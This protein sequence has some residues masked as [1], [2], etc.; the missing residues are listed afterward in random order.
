ML[1][2]V[3]ARWEIGRWQSRTAHYLRFSRNEATQLLISSNVPFGQNHIW[4]RHLHEDQNK[5]CHGVGQAQKAAIK[6]QRKAMD[7]M[8][9][10]MKR[11]YSELSS[12]QAELESA[13]GSITARS[14]RSQQPPP[15]T[16]L[17]ALR[18]L[19]SP[20]L[21]T[22]EQIVTCSGVWILS[23]NIILNNRLSQVSR[24]PCHRMQSPMNSR[25]PRPISSC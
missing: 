18:S 2:V 4:V 3:L 24:H 22:G 10:A 11:T 15:A 5:K 9:Q 12:E 1:N 13:L 6:A 17:S 19:P 20:A 7:E 21:L 14:L 16:I 8:F 23:T 25:S